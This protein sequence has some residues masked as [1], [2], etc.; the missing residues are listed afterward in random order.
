M[1]KGIIMDEISK[2][3]Q[4]NMGLVYN[5]IHQHFPNFLND[6]FIQVGRIALWKAITT[7]D[8]NKGYAFSSYA[9][10][11]IKNSI[12]TELGTKY[13]QNR[14]LISLDE[15]ISD[16]S[17]DT[18]VL[19]IEN[20]KLYQMLLNKEYSID[21]LNLTPLQLKI[22]ELLKLEYSQQEIAEITGENRRKIIRQIKKIRRILASEWQ[23]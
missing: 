2:K 14:K 22:I 21:N 18:R 8:E 20:K 1:G 12:K 6:D 17:D 11:I 5:V 3:I 10:K 19:L 13:R 23:I 16:K 15:C 4:D 9:T 7:F